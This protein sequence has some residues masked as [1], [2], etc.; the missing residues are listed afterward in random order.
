MLR[1]WDSQARAS[2]LF[3]IFHKFTGMKPMEWMNQLPKNDTWH[4]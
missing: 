2:S 4:A 1:V 3:C